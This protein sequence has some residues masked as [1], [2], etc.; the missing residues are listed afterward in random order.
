MDL[1][2]YTNK[3]LFVS[4]FFLLVVI[5]CFML[6]EKKRE[7][8]LKKEKHLFYAISRNDPELLLQMIREGHDVNTKWNGWSTTDAALKWTRP[9]VRG[10]TFILKD[11]QDWDNKASSLINIMI[12]NGLNIKSLDPPPLS[13]AAY[14]H[15]ENT[16]KIL[17][18]A[19]ANPN[20]GTK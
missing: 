16:V 15:L 18:G 5:A 2:K 6:A 4:L 13:F 20:V 10:K 19:G 14:W 9:K 1:I 7:A 3:A 12:Q 11:L 8:R 17:L